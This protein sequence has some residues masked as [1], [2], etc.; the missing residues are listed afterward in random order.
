MSRT[1]GFAVAVSEDLGFVSVTR[2]DRMGGFAN[3][4]IVGDVWG[5]GTDTEG[6]SDDG[7]ERGR[8]NVLGG[9]RFTNLR[10]N[11]SAPSTSP[12]L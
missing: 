6:M 2:V 1:K 12:A 10:S 3:S 8:I 7:E 11:A 5:A 9:Y 4:A